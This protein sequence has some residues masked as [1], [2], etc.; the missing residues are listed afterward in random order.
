MLLGIASGNTFLEHTDGSVAGTIS[1]L[2]PDLVAVAKQAFYD[3]GERPI[4]AERV[5]YGT[6]KQLAI[7]LSYITDYGEADSQG[8][9]IFSGR[10]EGFSLYFSRLVRPLW[11]STLTK[12]G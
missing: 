8:T 7:Y 6:S 2:S 9:A 12:P 3:F 1:V 11:R 4:W 10:R 5:T